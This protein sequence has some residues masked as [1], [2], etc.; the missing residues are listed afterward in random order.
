[1]AFVLLVSGVALTSGRS[2]GNEAS[3]IRNLAASESDPESF[4]GCV[5]QATSD[6][7]YEA[8]E[9]CKTLYEPTAPA[10]PVISFMSGFENALGSGS[11][12][13]PFQI[14]LG[15]SGEGFQY[16]T[17]WSIN[18]PDDDVFWFDNKPTLSKKTIWENMP[19]NQPDMIIWSALKIGVN[20][21]HTIPNK[22]IGGLNPPASGSFKRLCEH[23]TETLE[24]GSYKWTFDWNLTTSGQII[25]PAPS[26]Y[27]DVTAPAEPVISFMSGFE[28]ALGSGSEEDPFQISLGESGEGFQYLTT[29]SIN[30][31]D[32]DVFWFDNKPTLSKKTIWENMP[33][34]Q[35][36]MIIWSALKIGVNCLH[37]IPNKSIGGLN[38]PASGS[39]KRLCEHKTETLEA[40]SYKWTFDWNLTTSGQIIDPAPSVYFDVTAP[41]EPDREATDDK[42]SDRPRR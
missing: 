5:E 25:D 22:S 2:P 14:S 37:T 23:K 9:A 7:D 20:C 13:D 21:L 12:E 36:D 17:T 34:N 41:A 1:M 15:E 35:P 4:W 30:D 40:G 19:F 3:R 39:F 28:N 32:D 29:W 10:E 38:P 18:D 27:F 16:L 31:P 26:V 6:E 24:A 8:L 42:P 11:E 33:F